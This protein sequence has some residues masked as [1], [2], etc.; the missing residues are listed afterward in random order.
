[1][2]VPEG[3]GAWG[4]L[5]E[6]ELE[7][8]VTHHNSSRR[9]SFFILSYLLFLLFGRPTAAPTIEKF[10]FLLYNKNNKTSFAR[11]I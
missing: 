8:W 11:G 1:M 5:G 3:M 4:V 2:G 6:A 7:G 10:I 9:D